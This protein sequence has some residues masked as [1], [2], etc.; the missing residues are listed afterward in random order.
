MKKV[1][2]L[3]YSIIAAFFLLFSSCNQQTSSEENRYLFSYF[4]GNGE[5]GLHLAWSEDG[6]I[7]HELNNGQPILEPT[8]GEDKLMRDPCIIQGPDGRYHMVWTVSWNERGIGY[9]WS[10]D[11][12]NWSEQQ[13]I[14][15]ME[16]EPNAR[17]TWAPEITYDEKNDKF[18]IYWATTITGLYPETFSELEDGLNHRMYYVTTKDFKEFS[19]TK[20]LYEP[21]FSVIDSHIVPHNGEFIM[22]LKDETIEPPAKSLHVATSKNLTGPYSQPLVQ[23]TGDYWAEGP[24]SLYIDGTWIVYFD[25]YIEWTMGAVKSTDL[26]N[27]EEISHKISFPSEVRHGTALKI[28]K[29]VLNNLKQQLN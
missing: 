13:Y 6:L 1:N 21:G 23:I 27:W 15:V 10:E 22:F 12:I 5:S 19:E 7:W 17:N 9:A 8:A 24:T 26:E 4:K 20:L 3:I 28:E 25:K 11:L 2:L 14:P 18:M 16:H 29:E